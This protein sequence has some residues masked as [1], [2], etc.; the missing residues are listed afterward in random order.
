[1][2]TGVSRT[3]ADAS[4]VP[5]LHS[6]LAGRQ[7][8]SGS[9]RETPSHPLPFLSP[10][11]H[12]AVLKASAGTS[13]PNVSHTAIAFAGTEDI[14][15]DGSHSTSTNT[16]RYVAQTAG[17]YDISSVVAMTTVT[18][19]AESYHR[20]NGTTKH[21]AGSWTTGTASH[22]RRINV[23]GKMFLSVGHYA[24]VMLYHE[25]GSTIATNAADSRFELEWR[26][27]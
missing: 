19:Y 16:S 27:I 3:P 10:R 24:E 18:G 1:M 12:R 22:D 17:W 4:D 23:K 11:I 20:K 15:R 26:S 7:V 9:A 25:V 5:A 8:F 21:A 13:C 14:D 6:A 2:V